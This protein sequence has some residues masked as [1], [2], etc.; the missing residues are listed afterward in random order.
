M[1]VFVF[2]QQSVN[3][4]RTRF[5]LIIGNL[6]EASTGKAVSF[7][8][9]KLK[10]IENDSVVLHG[11]SDKNGFFEFNNLVFGHYRLYISSIGLVETILDSV[12]LRNDRY[13]FNIGDV[14]M[15]AQNNLLNEVIVYAEKPLIENKDDKLTYNIGESALS[16]GSSTAEIL[17]NIPLINN[18]PNGKILLKG[19]EPKILIDDKPTELNAQQL[20]DLLESLPGNSIEKI[21]VMTNPPPQYATEAGGV[22]NIVTKK[23]KIGWVGKVNATVG[24]RGEANFSGNLSY[25]NKKISFNQSIGYGYSQIKNSNYS[26]RQNIYLD[27]TNHLFSDG[28]ALNKNNRPNWRS[29]VD[30]EINKSNLLGVVFQSNLNYFDNNSFNTYNSYNRFNEL[31][32]INTRENTSIGSGITNSLTLSYTHK[33][34]SPN[35]VLRFILTGNLSD[36]NSNRNFFQQLYSANLLTTSVDSNLNQLLANNNLSVSTRV[37]YTKTFKKKTDYF[38]S[39][40]SYNFSNFHN[41]LQTNYFRQIDKL[42]VPLDLLSNDFKNFQ[43]IFSFRAGISILLK[44]NVRISVG[45]QA[46][47]TLIN[48]DF[49]KGN[50][51]NVINS[52]WNVLP[53]ATWRKEFNKELNTSMVYRATIK[54]PGITELNPNIDYTDPFTIRFGNPFL[55]PALAHN[56]D[57]TINWLKGKYYINT[58][59]G[60]NKLQ[61]VY[62]SIRSLV[63]AGKTQVTWVNIAERKE[64]EAN[65]YGGYTFSKLFRVNASISFTYNQYSEQEKNI[66]SYIDG[67]SLYSNINFNYTP[68]N[69]ITLEGSARYNNFADPQGRSR[70]SVNTNLGIQ[71]KLFDRRLVVAFNIIDLFT[72][73]QYV[74]ISQGKKFYIESVN[75]TSTRNFRVSVSYQLNKLIQ[76]SKILTKSLQQKLKKNN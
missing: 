30:Y 10:L 71:R 69:L 74:A 4:N 66:Y 22:I 34:N 11:I 36:N 32:K 64:Y 23:G 2:A 45:A 6:V 73:Q 65:V 8:N 26:N 42:M 13:D 50:V 40:I 28:H 9:I 51:S 27:S 68:T 16:N 24:S 12:F 76:K 48:F 31:Y 44:H 60:F 55:K 58:S 53:N 61:N 25:R 37:D 3:N 41:N 33:G 70:S 19:K 43:S 46:E 72:P 39:G 38:S 67:S 63:D 29:Q 62:N 18:D 14:K 15:K 5:G 21:E 35:D 59:L 20:Q 49:I 17:K 52:Y 75:T 47:H 57:W 54:R 56:F 7:A 1:S